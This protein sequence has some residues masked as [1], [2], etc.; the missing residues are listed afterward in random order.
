VTEDLLAAGERPG[1]SPREEPSPN[2]WLERGLRV[3]TA[4]ALG[5]DTYVHAHDASHYDFPGG[6]AISQGNLF[7]IEAAAA[8]LVAL[9]L[10]IWR[11]RAV[12]LV[13][14]AVAASALGALL[15]YRYIDV[16]VLGPLPNMYEPTWAVPGKQLAAWAEAVAVLT[17]AAGVSRRQSRPSNG[18][19]ADPPDVTR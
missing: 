4:A 19:R 5:I 2:R 11:H 18:H 1:T 12:W 9:L 15:L 16:G 10:L 13:A 3:A 8:A 17:S 6:G 7:R 14:F